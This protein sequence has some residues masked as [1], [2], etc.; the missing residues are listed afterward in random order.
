M[1][2]KKEGKGILK[3]TDN[4]REYQGEFKDDLRHGY[5][6]FTWNHGTKSYRGQW[7]FGFRNGMGFVRDELEYAEKAG[8]WC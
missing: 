6:K 1:K 2:N 7:E 5:G 4:S 3:W 8:Q